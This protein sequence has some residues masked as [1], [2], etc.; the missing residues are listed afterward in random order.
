[1]IPK[2]VEELERLY[3]DSESVDK[4]LYSEMRS[5]IL[6]I[7]GEHYTKNVNKHF[8]RLRETNRLTETL[9][10]RLTK[11][12]IH[13]VHRYYTNS[14]LSKVPGVTCVPHNE[15]EMQDQKQAELNNVVLS[16]IKRKHK[17]KDKIRKW[18][19]EF[20]GIGEV[21]TKV[22]WDSNK[23]DLL[24]YEQKVDEA[25][26]PYFIDSR[27]GEPTL[28]PGIPEQPYKQGSVEMGIPDQPPVPFQPFE[29]MPDESLP[30][31]S[32]DFVFEPL[33]GFN[34]W[35]SPGAKSMDD[36][37][38]IGLRK[39]VEVEELK[40]LYRDSEE[41]M[42]SI[43]TSTHQDYI[44]FDSSKSAYEKKEKWTLLKECYWRPCSRYPE[45]YFKI[46]TEFGVL[47]EG[48]LP[49]GIFPIKWKGFDEYPST[50]RGRSIIKVCRPYQA[51]LNRAASQRATHQITL[52][53]DK[54]LYQAGSKLAPG[55]LLPGVRG[56]SYQGAPPTVIAG[57]TGEQ[58][59]NY[60]NEEKNEMYEAAMI[61]EQSE[62]VS[63]QMD[64]YSLLFR[65]IS[66]QAKYKNYVEKFEEF[67][68]E[69]MELVLELA[70]YYMND[71]QLAQIFGPQE[72]VNLAEF[73]RPGRL[74][75]A[76]KLE[77][78][79][80]SVD[81]MMGKQV[82]FNH[83]LQYVG[84]NLAPDQLGQILRNMPFVNNEEIFSD[85]TI[86]F[87]NVRNDM[88]AIERGEQVT[89]SP[90]ANNE[91][92]I[93]KLTHRMKQPDFKSLPPQVQMQYQNLLQGHQQEIVRK[94]Q[95]II[96]AKNE[97]IPIGG[98]MVAVDMYVPDKEDP[99]KAPKRARIPYQAVEWLLQM[100]EK[101][102]MSLD[103]LETMN[104]GALADMAQQLKAGGASRPPEESAI[105]RQKMQ[106][107]YQ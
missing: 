90:F 92:Y 48:T 65:S 18:A 40:H 49:Y 30:V 86:D 78:Q 76:I 63:A 95:A 69:V 97:Y 9:K 81:T 11:N 2:N 5:N 88:L 85:L 3:N 1:M 37:P 14:I 54:I 50:P 42:K 75:Y 16:H 8:A 107:L 7:A 84:K 72:T 52:G 96:D 73:R 47:E 39:M 32:G 57:R 12:H 43:E 66:Q 10:L 93:K 44:I 100:L 21:A 91:Y 45:G 23:G 62:E 98:A 79:T 26:R 35:R 82:T 27:T 36:S 74:R 58:Y 22:F 68:V 53:D 29:P 61:N 4:E 105:N 24:G 60:I 87:D 80:D 94:Q 70:R 28:E 101:Q 67:V 34:L 51:E 59:G 77:P 41:K 55:A 71:D 17:L 64:P 31:Y 13:K 46:W 19:S 102:G 103:K 83:L 56:I 104:K 38:Y 99:S 33:F 25:G 89:V 15:T 20:T 106:Q 6:L